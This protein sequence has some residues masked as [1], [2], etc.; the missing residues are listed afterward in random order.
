MMLELE[1]EV[2]GEPDKVEIMD[3]L[4]EAPAWPGSREMKNI[5]G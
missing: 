3:N 4:G 5:E 1:V 2:E